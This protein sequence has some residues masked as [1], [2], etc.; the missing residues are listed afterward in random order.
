MKT[1]PATLILQH[2]RMLVIVPRGRL[3]NDGIRGCSE[4][5]RRSGFLKGKEVV[6][7]VMWRY[8]YTRLRSSQLLFEDSQ[9]DQS[10]FGIDLGQ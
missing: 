9:R 6:G 5:L 4:W 2:S 1:R 8:G 7:T 10:D 3:P